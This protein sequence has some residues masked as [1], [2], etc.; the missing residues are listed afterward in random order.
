[1]NFNLYSLLAILNIRMGLKLTFS[2]PYIAL[3]KKFFL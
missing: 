3:K 1:M 2:V